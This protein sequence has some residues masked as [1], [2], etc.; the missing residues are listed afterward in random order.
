MRE[1]SVCEFAPPQWNSF[2][3]ELTQKKI[4]GTDSGFPGYR[5]IPRSE[6]VEQTDDEERREPGPVSHRDGGLLHAGL[7]A[8]PG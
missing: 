4:R 7:G 8:C 6:K 2:H 1:N 5:F 3:G